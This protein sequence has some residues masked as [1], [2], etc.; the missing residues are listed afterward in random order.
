M[1]MDDE[2]LNESH[3]QSGAED[4]VAPL[5]H[6][7]GPRPRLPEERVAP[8]RT[9]AREVFRRQARRMARR[10][11]IGW[12]V[13]A[14]LA[15]S[16]LLTV[17]LVVRGPAG[18]HSQQPVAIFEVRSGAVAATDTMGRPARLQT[19]LAGTVVTTG[20][21]GRA[22]VRLPSGPAVR[23][24][25]ESSV[26]FDSSRA[27]TLERGALYVD[28]GAARPRDSG[29]EIATALGSVRDVG[30]QFEARLLQEPVSASLR[31]RVREGKVLVT[32]GS[33]EHQAR[34]GGEL[35]LHANGSLQRKEVAIYG[36]GWDWVQHVAPALAI[37]GVSLA[38]F[39]RW[40][41]RETGLRWRFAEPRAGKAPED[42]ILHGS[43]DGLT[44][45][46][47]LTVVLPG[48]GYRHRLRGDQLWLES[49]A[50]PGT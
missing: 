37:E 32:H 4:D 9:A 31:I 20:A 3:P 24:D 39:L 50:K 6:L 8:I 10:R 45:E 17:G 12:A 46:E 35:L 34:A 19:V 48:C 40:V 22:A 1:I 28:S 26:R 13:G 49:A 15:A 27:M 21:G 30:T 43:I 14:G 38:D 7:A 47:A 16:L 41:S 18:R 5:L 44:A 42:I 33:E 25:A 23:I 29:I 36:S 11:R 2:N